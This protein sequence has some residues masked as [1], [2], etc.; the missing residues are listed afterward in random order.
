[1]NLQQ[2]KEKAQTFGLQGVNKMRKADLVRGIQQAEGN[3][4]CYGAAWRAECNELGCCWR[5]DCL[6]EKTL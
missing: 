6:K 3:S 1:M 5:E 2:I 4:P